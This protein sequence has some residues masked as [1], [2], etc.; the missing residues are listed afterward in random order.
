MSNG[1]QQDT[2]QPRSVRFGKTSL[3]IVIGL[4]AVTIVGAHLGM[5]GVDHG[6]FALAGFLVVATLTWTWTTFIEKTATQRF[7]LWVASFAGFGLAAGE[8]FGRWGQYLQDGVAAGLAFGLLTAAPLWVIRRLEGREVLFRRVVACASCLTA[9]V[10]VTVAFTTT[11]GGWQRDRLYPPPGGKIAFHSDREGQFDIYVMKPDGSEVTRLTDAPRSDMNPAWSPDGTKIAYESGYRPHFDIYVMDADGANATRLTYD[12]AHDRHPVWSPDGARIAFQSDRDG[13]HEI[14]LINSDG[15][16]LSRLTN[17]PADDGAP[18]WSPDGSMIAFHSNRSGD[19]EPESYEIYVVTL[20][21]SEVTRLTRNDAWDGNP[22][23][24]RDGRRIAFE[25]ERDRGL[26]SRALRNA[27]EIYI[28]DSDGT[29][30]KALTRD[31][32]KPN[33][34][35][36]W[37]PSGR[38]IAYESGNHPQHEIYVVNADGTDTY[39][40]TDSRDEN[41]GPSWGTPAE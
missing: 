29:R 9:L 7:L 20:D 26:I 41:A 35:P 28:M 4:G 11:A 5:I 36:S 34:S 19:G 38:Q 32:N 16:G 27:H 22:R 21:S 24:S 40:L 14:Y 23:W 31:Y 25:S 2:I 37:S 1:S 30:A 13:N 10:V 6:R 39:R 15:T 33:K 18:S 3:G 8:L 17:N 12:I